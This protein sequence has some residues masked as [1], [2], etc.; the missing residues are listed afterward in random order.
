[1]NRCLLTLALVALIGPAALAEVEVQLELNQQF[2][3]EGDP[4]NVRVTV[5]NGGDAEVANPIKGDLYQAFVAGLLG[6]DSFETP[7]KGLPDSPNRPDKLAPGAFYGGILD[8]TEMFP[9][10]LEVGRYRLHWSAD[11]LLSEQFEIQVIP[12]FDAAKKYE[13]RLKTT[14]GDIIVDL[15]QR[16]SPVAAKAFIDLANSDYYDGLQFH[17]VRP[18]QFIVGGSARAIGRPDPG[19][20][21]PAELSAMP[22]VAGSVLIKPTGAAPPANGTEFIISLKPQTGWQGQVTVVGQVRKGLDIVQKISKVASSGP[23]ANRPTVPVAIRDVEIVEVGN[24]R[25]AG[26]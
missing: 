15:F 4:L 8:V 13:A 23:P 24:P 3:Y 20:R 2:F 18:N 16:R 9:K 1:M 14:E 5:R 22:I 11:G 10:L 12:K 17:E 25:A 7:K 6:G 19:F 21:Y 26:S